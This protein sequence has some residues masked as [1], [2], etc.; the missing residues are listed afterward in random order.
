MPI[1]EYVCSSCDAKFELLR[2]FNE[3][4][5]EASCPHCHHNAERIVSACASF[6]K[7]ETGEVSSLAGTGGSCTSC[8]ATNCSTCG[9]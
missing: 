6:S 4:A 5:K 3:S 9:I 8:A 2:S 1:Y 7:S